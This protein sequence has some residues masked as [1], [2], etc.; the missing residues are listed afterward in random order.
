MPGKGVTKISIRPGFSRPLAVYLLSLH[1]FALGL[2]V[3]LPLQ[4]AYRIPLTILIIFSLF[5]YRRRYLSPQGGRGVTAME[6]RGEQEWILHNALG[7]SETVYLSG[8]SYIHPRLLILN[9]KT[10]AGKRRSLCLTTDR[11]DREQLRR[12]RTRL[13]GLRSGYS[14]GR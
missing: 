2:I 3:L 12:L 7:E 6:W 1:G 8:S 5:H 10:A 4:W 11:V 14:G 9:F 13:Y